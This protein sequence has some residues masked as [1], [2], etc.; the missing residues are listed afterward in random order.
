VR[1]LLAALLLSLLPAV[2]LA[3]TGSV[4]TQS[5]LNTLIGTTGCTQPTCLLPDNNVG[6]IT[7]FDVRQVLLNMNSTMFG[8]ASRILMLAD[9]TFYVN[10]NTAGSA[11]CGITGAL[12]CG[13]G[14][15]S[16]TAIQAENPATPFA[17]LQIA[18]AVISN[19]FDYGGHT[20]TINLAHGTD[21]GGA[22]CSSTGANI[23]RNGLFINGDNNAPTAAQI[24]AVNGGAAVVARDKCSLVL[25]SV[26]IIDQGSALIGLGVD[27]QSVM[28]L[29]GVSFGAFNASAAQVFLMQNGSMN[30]AATCGATLL[31]GAGNFLKAQD[32][33]T[34]AL[35]TGTP[36]TL[37]QT[38]CIPSAVGYTATVNLSGNATVTGATSGSF[39]GLGVAGTTGFR[40]AMS[41]SSNVQTAGAGI[42]A[43]F[44]GSLPATLVGFA[45]TDVLTD[46]LTTAIPV[47]SGGTGT[48]TQFTSGSVPFAGAG[49][50]YSQDN[51]NFFYDATNHRLGVGT[52]APVTGLEVFENA[53]PTERG[54]GIAGGVLTLPD[55]TSGGWTAISFGLQ[56]V[57]GHVRF[58]GTNASPLALGANEEIGRLSWGGWTGSAIA[59]NKARV[60]CFT[61]EAFTPSANGTYCDVVAT[62]PTTTNFFS[63]ARFHGDGHFLNIFSG[64]APTISSCGTT[65][66][67]SGN[68]NVGTITAGSGALSSCVMN[69][70]KPWG[71]APVCTFSS[72]TAVAAPTVNTST[73]QLTIGGT[74][75]TSLTLNY[76]CQSN[77]A[78]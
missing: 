76:I 68:D 38:I 71:T 75:L 15:N 45:T 2:A 4:M 9:T 52:A 31:G 1:K 41:G 14:N 64:A 48:K 74:S 10:P 13:A 35:S 72:P 66:S 40:A 55:A 3:Q 36:P 39:T 25:T 60:A 61:A 17:S 73:T 22:Q 49:G 58:D 65:P 33:S 67:V 5:Q 47:Q 30:V 32:N 28:D 23:G 69:F 43:V 27:Q 7:P 63:V 78:S 42:N 6:A 51:A 19:T 56:A 20:P 44:P 53:T 46:Y 12:T 54:T 8:G 29:S 37:P 59:S 24:T 11:T 70:A 62:L 16:V 21:P 57:T 34:F 77:G 18:M 50:V 26:E